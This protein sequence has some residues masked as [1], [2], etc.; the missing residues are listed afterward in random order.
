MSHRILIAE[1][2]AN[3]RTVLR[4]MLAE[5][6]VEILEAA[7]GAEALQTIERTAVDLVITDVN[8]PHLSGL[9]LLSQLRSRSTAPPVVVMTAYASV[10][11]AVSA[12]QCGAIDYL[13]KPFDEQRLLL[14]LRRALHMTD[15]LAENAR[16]RDDLRSR[17]DF[18]S[19]LGESPALLS[20]LKTAS[21]VA[22]SDANVLIQGESGTGK[23]LFAR[24][25]HVNS[26]R[27]R[28]PFIALNCAAIPEGLLE[29]ELFGAEAGAYTGATKRRRGRV[30]LARGGTLF[31]DEVGDMPLP[32]QAK[33]LRLVQERTY[34]PLGAEAELKADVRFVFA[35]HRD[36]AQLVKEGRFR[37]DLRYRVSVV[38]VTLP[39]LRD[40]GDDVLLIADA[41]CARVCESM[42]RKPLPLSAH[43]R[44]ALAQHDWP[45]NIRELGN[46]IER[47]VILSDGDGIDVADLDLP[48]ALPPIDPSSP[49]IAVVSSPATEPT[50]SWVL[51]EQGLS[52]DALERNLV[53]QALERVRGNKSQAARLLGLTRATLR[54]RIEKMGLSAIDDDS[55]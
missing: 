43:A 20:A 25:I 52:L 16:L 45:G 34:Q 10:D 47:A 26:Q 53:S 48:T 11:D 3:Y 8:M 5:L 17:F 49:T 14:T 41:A 36:L 2:E 31:L 19:I 27:R 38:P 28:G 13:T 15:L 22:G 44:A 35:T 29:A 40:R 9:E 30:E 55:A 37:E 1:D 51:P 54:Y 23:E 39:P 32:L 50:T 42:G 21:K 33:L 7:D 46:V 18:S 24:A 6:D 12:M 4:L